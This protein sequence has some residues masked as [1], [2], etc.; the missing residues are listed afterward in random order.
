MFE[1]FEGEDEDMFTEID[2]D[3][4]EEVIKKNDTDF[5][6]NNMKTKAKDSSL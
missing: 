2:V 1:F 5:N 3:A 4:Y 6:V